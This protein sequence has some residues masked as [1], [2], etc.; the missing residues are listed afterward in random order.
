NSEV[1]HAG[2]YNPRGSLKAA[3]CVRGREML[4]E[5]CAEHNVPHSRCGKLLVATSRNQIPQLESIMAKGR[6]NGVLDLMR[7]NGDQAQALEPA[8][9]CVEAVFSPQ[10]G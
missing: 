1:I 4:Y 8:L 2:T 5:Y 7:I 9:E 10:T 3:L 6:E